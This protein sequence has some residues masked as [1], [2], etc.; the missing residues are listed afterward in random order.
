MGMTQLKGQLKGMM[1]TWFIKMKKLIQ[2]FMS[3]INSENDIKLLVKYLRK[4]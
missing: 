1:F 4:K 3:S 2:C